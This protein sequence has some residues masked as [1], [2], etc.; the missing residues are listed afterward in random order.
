MKT[1]LILLLFSLAILNGCKSTKETAR[2]KINPK[3]SWMLTPPTDPGYYH[4]IGMTKK[5]GSRPTYQANAHDQALSKL[6][7]QINAHISTSSVLSQVEDRHGV[8][9]ILINNIK[10]TSKEFL[11]GY[12][13]VGS[14]ED[15]E[16][17]YEYYR[18]SR[19][20]FAQ[21]KEKR[22]Q[23]ALRN[24]ASKYSEAQLQEKEGNVSLAIQLYTSTLDIL[25]NH[26]NESTLI[27]DSITT[28]D[29]AISSIRQIK[30]LVNSLKLLPSSSMLVV[31]KGQMIPEEMLIFKVISIN[32]VPQPN[33]PVAFEYSG[34]YLRK[35]KALS[36]SEGTVT[37]AIHQPGEK[38]GKNSFS[39][40]ID[41]RTLTQMNTKNLLVRKLIEDIGGSS[42]TVEI[43]IN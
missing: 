30:S 22:R 20:Q 28:F 9:E 17:Y 15:D 4:G 10:S 31:D 19:Q 16:Y 12:E 6:A 25:S 42:T 13:Q 35:D 23:D 29:P 34:G 38:N 41:I 5:W 36:S 32:G 43:N 14:Y 1:Q 40:R 7:G 21:L 3:P 24:A 11:E 26:L 2:E 39:A 27:N 18:L 37:T 8:S 33:I